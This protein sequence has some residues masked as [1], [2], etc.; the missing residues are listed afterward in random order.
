MTRGCRGVGRLLDFE[1]LAQTLR[2]LR[3]TQLGECLR[4]DLSD[5]FP[6]YPELLA[7]L[8]EGLRTSTVEPEAQPDDLLLAL[9]QLA[10]YLAH[11]I[12]QHHAGGGVGGTVD[13]AVLDEVAEIRFV[14][15]AHRRVERQQIL[16]VAKQFADSIR[17]E[18]DPF[19]E[20]G[21]SR[22]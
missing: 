10:E 8:F 9:G 6:G 22:L 12:V 7:H 5:P 21:N 3:M 2:A 18:L 14:L 4:L 11:G 1:E 16:R 15:L 19:G 13:R 17:I 20:L